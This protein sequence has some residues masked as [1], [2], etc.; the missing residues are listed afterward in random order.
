MFDFLANPSG[1]MKKT[2]GNG[3]LKSSNSEIMNTNLSFI[4]LFV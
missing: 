4:S 1:E 3:H 2:E